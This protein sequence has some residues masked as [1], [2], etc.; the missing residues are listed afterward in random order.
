MEMITMMDMA[1]IT[2]MVEETMG[3]DIMMPKKVVTTIETI[4]MMTGIRDILLPIMAGVVGTGIMMVIMEG[5]G[6]V[7]VIM[8]TKGGITRMIEV[9]DLHRVA[10]PKQNCP[11]SLPP[12][13]ANWA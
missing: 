4:S 3:E 2:K 10:N 5:A 13:T 7:V 12:P 1:I 9:V 11:R 8:M 6:V